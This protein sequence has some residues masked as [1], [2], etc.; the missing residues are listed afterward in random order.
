MITIRIGFKNEVMRKILENEFKYE[1]KKENPDWDFLENKALGLA[2]IWTL[3]ALE[4]KKIKNKEV[5][6]NDSDR[7]ELNE[8]HNSQG[9]KND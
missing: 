8:T 3:R 2:N 6:N 1:F 9:F 5:K 7:Q 4:I